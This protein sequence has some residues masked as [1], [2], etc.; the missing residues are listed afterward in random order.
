MKADAEGSEPSRSNVLREPQGMG[1]GDSSLPVMLGAGSCCSPF[2][3]SSAHI[4]AAP[5]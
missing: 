4:T 1:L 2:A 5:C 3:H